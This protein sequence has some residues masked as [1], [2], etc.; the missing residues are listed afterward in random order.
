ML[1]KIKIVELAKELL[2]AAYRGKEKYILLAKT[3]KSNI[4][5]G[6]KKSKGLINLKKL[7]V[8]P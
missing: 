7:V 5:R 6:V 1:N 3:K 4:K 2:S 8:K